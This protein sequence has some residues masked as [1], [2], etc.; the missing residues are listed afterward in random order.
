MAA[1]TL[2]TEL[3]YYLT[4]NPNNPPAGTVSSATSSQIILDFSE[5]TRISVSG[6]GFAYN[7]M[8]EPTAGTVSGLQIT[9]NGAVAVS[10]SN[11]S[12]P[13][14]SLIDYVESTNVG[15][16]LQNLLAG[17]DTITVQTQVGV[18]V[19]GYGGND[20]M[21]GGAGFEY[22]NGNQGNDV[23]DGGSGGNDWL[24]GGQGNDHI[25]AH[26]GNGVLYGNLGADTLN[27][28][29]G[30]EII[31]GG[32][33]SDMLNGGGGADWLAG[34]KGSDTV[35]GGSGADI[36]HISAGAGLDRITDFSA[37]EGDRVQLS[38]GQT[39]TVLQVGADTV[40][41]LGNGDQLVLAGVVHTSLAAGWIFSA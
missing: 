37:A 3:S 39:Y 12:V 1:L 25:T 11:L 41:D 6:S 34:D 17:S 9:H 15:G 10:L 4:L 21:Q 8:G 35:T 31:R 16:M 5:G 27:G 29:S 19:S 26:S 20:T 28:G 38:A 32:Q 22:F 18:L 13:V 30:A 24:V 36:F 40:V 14:T 2:G 23:I 33:D 7:G